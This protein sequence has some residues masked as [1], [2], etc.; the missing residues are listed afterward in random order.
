MSEPLS[1]AVSLAMGSEFLQFWVSQKVCGE[2]GG[3]HM[4]VESR[5]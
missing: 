2:P 1:R 3:R 4:P 5:W